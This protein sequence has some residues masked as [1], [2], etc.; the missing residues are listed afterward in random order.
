MRK[1]IYSYGDTIGRDGV[2]FLRELPPK[3]FTTGLDRMAMFH[4]PLCRETFNA[5]IQNVKKGITR[6]CGCLVTKTFTTHGLSK[7]YLYGVWV[8]MKARCYN[9]KERAYK[10]YGG[11]GIEVCDEWRE[12]FKIFYDYV[13]DLPNYDENN[14]GNS[15]LTIDRIKNNEGYKPRNIRWADKHTQITNRRKRARKPK[16]GFTGVYPVK[17][18]YTAFITVNYVRHYLGCFKKAQDGNKA[19]I[20]FILDNKLNEY[21]QF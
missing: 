12:D 21:I 13:T 20:K 15:G 3:K 10:W 14:L 7:H 16:S 19:R 2:T 8:A 9:K 11:R 6:S 5:C 18:G 17:C 1:I 4:C